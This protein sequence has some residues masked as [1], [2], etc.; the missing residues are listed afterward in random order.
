VTSEPVFS[1]EPPA[2]YAS[3]ELSRSADV[4]ADTGSFVDPA[5]SDAFTLDREPRDG[6][7][8]WREGLWRRLNTH[9]LLVAW[10]SPGADTRPRRLVAERDLSAP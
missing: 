2:T 4:R 10:F 8:L 1:F 9:P 7:G 6:V 3:V 5:Y